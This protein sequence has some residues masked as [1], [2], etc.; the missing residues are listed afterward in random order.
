[1]NE[2]Y[3]LNKMQ[4][5]RSE[6]QQVVLLQNEK[7]YLSQLWS[8]QRTQLKTKSTTILEV[9]NVCAAGFAHVNEMC[10]A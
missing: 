1:M 2:V 3:Q 10:Y 8:V 7:K 4:A 9:Q 5:D 6:E